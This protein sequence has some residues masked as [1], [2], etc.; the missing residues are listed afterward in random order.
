MMNDTISTTDSSHSTS[1]TTA[2]DFAE[3]I[4]DRFDV[5]CFDLDQCAVSR[6]SRGRL[7]R[8]NLDE[9]ASQISPDFVLAI[10]AL[11]SRN[12][13][14]AI[15]THSDLAQHGEPSKPRRGEGAVVLGDELVHEVLLRVVPEYAHEFFVVAWRPKSRGSEGTK[16]PGKIRHLR[17]CS[18]FYEAPLER[19][20]LFDD[21]PTNC[22]LTNLNGARFSAY[23]CDPD[24]GFRFTD[25]HENANHDYFLQRSDGTIDRLGRWDT[26]WN[27]EYKGKPRFHLP[28][29][30]PNL[31][32]YHGKEFNPPR[33]VPILLPLCGKTID[34]QWLMDAGHQCVVGVEGVRRG[35]EELADELLNDL[36]C[37][38]DST[39][40]I[41][42]TASDG[43]EWFPSG[44]SKASNTGL[45]RELNGDACISI[46]CD[47]FFR[48]SPKSFGSQ[49]DTKPCFAAVYD[50]AAIVAIPPHSRQQ[51]VDIIDSLLI[52]GG[53][54]L[55]ITV[56][57]GRDSGPPFTIT[58]G[59]VQELFATRDYST[60]ILEK[61]ES[62]F[63]KG[64]QE[65]VFL[66]T[67]TR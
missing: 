9:F 39:G 48:L 32:K 14:L 11:L 43:K 46:I 2:N 4:S 51:Y 18:A 27:L 58:P 36:R 53:Q 15:V 1:T 12:I 22:T 57:T 37:I 5:V 28:I 30:N 47:D 67:K 6:H 55:M 19:C 24:V 45:T 17:A 62:D 63:G 49:C 40:Y 33:D 61:R 25:F 65:Y 7:L 66:L 56:D 29:V 35:I 16:D 52:P 31:V 60:Q 8:K 54:L 26:K 3:K 50:R 23:K 34:L 10:P 38:D 20:V 44:D 13:K 21:D 59:V 42:T 41:W 64:S